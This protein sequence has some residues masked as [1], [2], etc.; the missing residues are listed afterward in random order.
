MNHLSI[1]VASLLLGLCGCSVSPGGGSGK[2]ADMASVLPDATSFA[3]YWYPHGAEISRYRL[4][5]ARYGEVHPGDAVLIFVTE[6][7]DP[8]MQ[9]KYEGSTPEADGAEAILKLNVSKSFVTGIYPYQ[10]MSSI[11]APLDLERFPL[12]LKITTSSQEWCGHTWTQ[13][14]LQEDKLY[15]VRQFSYFQSEG[16]VDEE[17]AAPHSEEGI[18][19]RLRIAPDTL[20]VGELRMIPATFYIR[21]SHRPIQA[22]R[23]TASL[24][25]EEGRGMNGEPLRRYTLHYPELGRTLAIR[26]WRAFPHVIEG[27]EETGPAAAGDSRLL[28]TSAERTHSMMLD[29]WNRNSPEDRELRRQL[30][31]PVN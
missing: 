6:N 31:L 26:F 13:L 28:T 16:D 4:S 14:N 19:T 17:V 29:Y 9:V 2:G 1:I 3:D 27:W 21:F 24:E 10:M 25:E 30:G 23:V 8:G 18:W 15:R 22:E 20:P 7:F 12:P 11:F 5:Q